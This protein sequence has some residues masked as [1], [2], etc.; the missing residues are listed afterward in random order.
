MKKANEIY[1]VDNGKWQ[2]ADSATRVGKLSLIQQVWALIDH[3][4]HRLQ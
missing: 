3:I 4:D 2:L 1:V